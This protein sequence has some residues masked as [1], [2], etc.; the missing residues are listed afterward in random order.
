MTPRSTLADETDL[1]AELDELRGVL[2]PFVVGEVSTLPKGVLVL[3]S[4]EDLK[5]AKRVYMASSWPVMDSPGGLLDEEEEKEWS[6]S[7]TPA[8]RESPAQ[9]ERSP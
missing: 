7:S 1:K 8:N 3:V 9:P 2:R 6:H 4:R 5:E